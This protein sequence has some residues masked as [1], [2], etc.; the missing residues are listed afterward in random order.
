MGCIVMMSPD[1][2]VHEA[3]EAL[4]GG[5]QDVEF[6]LRYEG[7][8]PACTQSNTRVPEKQAIRRHFHTQLAE[9]WRLDRRLSTLPIAS[10]P[11]AVRSDR[12]TFDVQRPIQGP[13]RFFYKCTKRGI[14][15]VPLVVA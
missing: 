5:G 15:F 1:I 2:L 7:E 9:L 8:L 3:L 11:E 4:W 10:L 14:C 6:T 12:F 13:T